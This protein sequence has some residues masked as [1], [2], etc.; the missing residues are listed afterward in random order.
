MLMLAPLPLGLN[1]PL[2]WTI[3]IVVL[4]LLCLTWPL[5]RWR[6]KPRF[7]APRT[8][9]AVPGLLAGTVVIWAIIQ[10]IPGMPPTMAHPVWQQ[11]AGVLALPVHASLSLAPDAT[12]DGILRLLGYIAAFWLAFVHGA[13][14]RR[15]LRL[16]EGLGIA[17]GLYAVYGLIVYLTGSETILWFDKWAYEGYL[18]GTFVNRN[19]YAAAAGLGL[20]CTMAAIAIRLEGRRPGWGPLILH[21]QKP[22]AV[23]VLAWVVLALSILASGSRAGF[24]SVTAGAIVFLAGMAVYG[25]EYGRRR[26]VMVLGALVVSIAAAWGAALVW[27]PSMD[28]LGNDRQQIYALVLRAIA[29]RPVLGHGLGSFPDLM[30]ILRTPAQN[31]VWVEVHNTYLE[32]MLELGIPSALLLLAA[33]GVIVGRVFQGIGSRVKGGAYPCLALA[34]TVQ[35]GL[36]SGVDFVAEIPAVTLAWVAILG[37]GAAQTRDLVRERR[38]R[39]VRSAAPEP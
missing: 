5:A 32:L 4:A 16:V 31:T 37:L 13:S 35:I 12:L 14:P 18:T 29:E 39:P 33:I 28:T 2:G 36:H 11:A 34:A 9:L 20:L 8:D 15:A 22:T 21:L 25:R 19:S 10:A 23:F 26:A 3:A 17:A 24:L 27:S 1:R 6:D 38:S 7:S 30:R